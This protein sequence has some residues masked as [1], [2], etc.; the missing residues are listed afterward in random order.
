MF[1]FKKKKSE[2]ASEQT[3]NRASLSDR[4]QRTRTGL[5]GDLFSRNKSII[6]NATL[7]EL[8]DRLIMADIGIK[9]TDQV[10]QLLKAEVKNNT[11][12]NP[13]EQLK[14]VLLPAL[15]PVEQALS[16]PDSANKPFL[17]L[18]IGVNGVGK[19]TTIGKLAKRFQN[20]GKSVMLAA[21][22]TFRA[23]A[24]E[25]LQIW[26]E[27]NDITV[28][29]QSH[30][31]DSGAVIYDALESARAKNIDVLIA[32][33]AGR[34][35]NKDNLMEEMKKI[36]RLGNKFD[37]D[38]QREVLLVLDAGTG[39]N[40][41]VQA[42]QFNDSVGVDGIVLTKLDGTAKGGIV[43]SL[44]NELNIP[45]RFIGIGEQIDDLRPFNASE[46]IDALLVNDK[47]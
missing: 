17:V 15:E 10:I 16:I 29:A 28:V 32:D 11:D 25:Q 7:E 27:R 37:P 42:K 46:F 9:T 12:T 35:H 41:L 19:T 39:Q 40:A 3:S 38:L 31:S 43:F 20:Q 18:V 13:L 8:E 24:I 5:F 6:D 47:E 45:I 26:G 14:Q 44:A 23:A 2:K 22:D 1:G 33:T 30:G 21:A 34:L 4:L 36:H